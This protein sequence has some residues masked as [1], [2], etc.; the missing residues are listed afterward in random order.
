MKVLCVAEKPSLAKSISQILSHGTTRTVKLC[1]WSSRIHL[2]IGLNATTF[3]VP[4]VAD[5][6][7]VQV[8]MTS[9]LGHLMAYDFPPE[10]QNWTQVSP[11]ALF[12]AP[13]EKHVIRGIEAV[14]DNIAKEARNAEQ[15]M[16]WTDCDREGENIG[17]EIVAVCRGANSRIRVS[18]A[19][20]S[21]IISQQIRHAWQSPVDLDYRQA[22]A[23]DAR[24]ELDLRIGAA[25]SRFQT[26]NLRSLFSELNNKV[27]SYGS[28]QFPTLGFVVDQY[29]KVQNFVTE[30]FWK[31]YVA[32]ER[33]GSMV[34]FHWVRNHLFDR[35]ACVIIYEKCL[36]NP[37][38]TVVEVNSKEHGSSLNILPK[39]LNDRKPYPLTTVELQKIGSRYL[40][41]SSDRLMNV[42]EQL[43]VK[44]FISYPRTETDQFD[45]QFD[46]R[47]LIEK[48]TQD[49]RWGDFAT[50]LLLAGEFRTPRNG[51]HND[52]AHPPIHP[53][54]YASDL[55]GDELKVYEF[56]VRRFLA[57]CSDHAVGHETTIEIRLWE[58]K[59]T[60]RGLVILARNY[61]DVYPYDRWG[62]SNLPNFQKGETFIPT[63]CEMREG[64]TSPPEYL[65]EADLISIMD[66][67]G[68]GTD[69]TIHVHIAKI[70]ERE[71]ARKDFR[72]GKTYILPSNLGVALVEGYDSIGFDKSLSKPF[73]RREMESKFKMVCEGRQQKEDVIKDSLAMYKD[74][75]I[76]TSENVQK[77]VRVRINFEY[78]TISTRL[79]MSGSNLNL[80]VSNNTPLERRPR[81]AQPTRCY[82]SSFQSAASIFRSSTTQSDSSQSDHPKCRCGLYAASNKTMSLG[83]NHGR[84]YFTCPKAGKK[85]TFFQWAD[86]ASS[87]G[88]GTR[89]TH[90]SSDSSTGNGTCY[91]CG[92]AGHF[93]NMCK[94]SKRTRTNATT[95]STVQ[96]RM[97]TSTCYKCNQVGHWSNNCPN[98]SSFNGSRGRGRGRGTISNRRSKRGRGSTRRDP[99]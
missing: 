2:L 63:T 42:A 93:A 6:R 3:M 91:N 61:L 86:G 70:I 11:L 39:T 21:A 9:V 13:T 1:L 43:Y 46:F 64:H 23:V 82:T 31:I 80:D 35:L 72:N 85:C 87:S 37:T 94:E 79:T 19:K 16:I 68:I 49:T 81:P 57:C 22:N 92:E 38:A 47:S 18:R 88:S 15:I 36:E 96:S 45:K 52:Q 74:M 59:F 30:I 67:N 75:Y 78:N 98:E 89:R 48:Q 73:L 62:E 60:A 69:A 24:S 5:N 28:C 14:R 83:V 41:I 27:I 54:L 58:E 53:T 56:V 97:S 17:S 12:D 50:R 66:Q 7:T 8:T 65:T 4:K 55:T 20:F 44:G 84:P 76:K 40:H 25:F 10:Y 34:E 26:L 51:S 90:A 95:N 33:D 29:L 99:V 32:L 71:Y 77:L